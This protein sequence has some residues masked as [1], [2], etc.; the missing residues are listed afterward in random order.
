MFRGCGLKKNIVH[1]CYNVKNVTKDPN[2]ESTVKLGTLVL[3][4]ISRYHKHSGTCPNKRLPNYPVTNSN[5]IVQCWM[6]WLI[7]ISPLPNKGGGRKGEGVWVDGVCVLWLPLIKTSIGKNC[8]SGYLIWELQKP[9]QEEREREIEW[10]TAR[11][12]LSSPR[13]KTSTILK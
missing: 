11:W 13:K 1:Y 8:S 3:Y 5:N 4:N 10:L 7:N 2:R 6:P 9:S 12:F